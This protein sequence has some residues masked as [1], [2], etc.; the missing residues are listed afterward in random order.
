MVNIGFWLFNTKYF[1]FVFR[2]RVLKTKILGASLVAIEQITSKLDLLAEILGV[3][4]RRI[5]Q[6]VEAEV[7]PKPEKQGQYDIPACVQ[8]YYYNEFCGELGEDG[9]DG[10]Q[11][12]ARKAKAEADRIEFDLAIKKNEYVAAELVLHEIEK[13][14]MN[15]RGK[16]L[17]MP[18]KFAPLLATAEN[19]NEAE[20]ILTDGINEALNELVTPGFDESNRGSEENTGAY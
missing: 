9:L 6:L 12:R 10:A 16:L 4:P 5:Q 17:A 15:C 14:I 2:L 18:R 3:T 19:P 7:I 8:A 20:K 13:S 1:R 11:E